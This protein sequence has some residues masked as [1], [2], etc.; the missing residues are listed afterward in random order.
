MRSAM[1]EEMRS[2][3]EKLDRLV[4]AMDAAKGSDKV[5]AIAAVVKELVAQH[6][7]RLERMQSRGRPRPQGQPGTADEDGK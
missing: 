2:Q 5:D 4:A 3:Q 7:A 1:M 6:G